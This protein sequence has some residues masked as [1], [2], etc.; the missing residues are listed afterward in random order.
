VDTLFIV[1][2]IIEALFGI[3]FV[4]APVAMLGPFGVTFNA[5]A[6]TFA[7]LF[8]SALISFP[9]LLWFAR[10]SDKPEFKKGG[11]LQSICLLSCKHCAPRDSSISRPNERSSLERDRHIRDTPG[12]VRMLPRE[13]D[14]RQQFAHRE[15][16]F[17][18]YPTDMR[19]WH[20]EVV[21]F[22]CIGSQVK[23][24]WPESNRVLRSTR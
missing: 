2:L 20:Q 12:L 22:A 13:V 3:G 15:C 14:S 16:D 1:A 8:G 23:R 10:K 5:I 11:G 7:R 6:A 18:H 9:M 17:T 4:I 19:P 24:E 21:C